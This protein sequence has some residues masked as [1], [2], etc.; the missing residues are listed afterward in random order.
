MSSKLRITSTAQTFTAGATSGTITVE[1]DD[2]SNN[3]VTTGTTT[4]DMT[5]SSAA[6]LFRNTADSATITSVTITAGTSSASFRY[7][8]TTAG[9]PT[10]TAADHAGVLTSGT[11]SETVNPSTATKLAF[12]VSPGATSADNAFTPQPQVTVQDTYGNTVTSNSSSVTIAIKAGYRD[13]RRDDR[14][15]RREPKSAASGVATFSGCQITKT[16]T[17]YVLH[18]T[19]GALTAA[20][21]TAF[22]ITAG[23]AAKVA[24]TPTPRASPPARPRMSRSPSSS[25]TSS[26][27]TPRA[28]GRPA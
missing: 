5:T 18:A 25:R 21:G 19:D 24:I 8:D 27:T 3:P 16:G 14:Q 4:V 26:G 2:S 12:T 17:G 23:A 28:A 11:Q 6:G 9:S 15:L 22:N 1:R 10:I 7:R 20:D 13:I